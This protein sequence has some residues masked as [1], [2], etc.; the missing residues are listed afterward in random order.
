MQGRRGGRGTQVSASLKAAP[1]LPAPRAGH[2]DVKIGP[3]Q[4]FFGNTRMNALQ[5]RLFEPVIAI[6]VSAALISVVLGLTILLRRKGTPVHRLQGQLWVGAMF[7]V[8]AS[9]FLIESQTMPLAIPQ[10]PALARFGPIHL[11]SV[12]TLVTLWG[13]IRAIR[14]GK[15]RT[16]RL[17]MISLYASLCIAGLFTLLPS[18][19]LGAW[20]VAIFT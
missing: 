15:V 6:H 18:R 13:G 12:I 9:S 7:V 19:I 16:H 20:L 17:N 4:I 5:A 11:L 14:A 10:L 3:N 2:G 1:G 8:A